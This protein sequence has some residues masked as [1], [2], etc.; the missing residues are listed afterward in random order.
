MRMYN[1][2]NLI[3]FFLVLFL[4][5]FTACSETE[6]IKEPS[7]I[8]TKSLTFESNQIDEHIVT[9]FAGSDWTASLS[10]TS[11]IQIDPTTKVGPKGEAKVILSCRANDG[12]KE[13]TS[14]LTLKVENE[15]PY[16][17]KITQVPQGSYLIIDTEQVVF[18]VDPLL[19]N[20]KGAFV[21]QLNV[22]SNSKWAIRA[23]PE[24]V[25]YVAGD[26]KESIDGIQTSINLI[27]RAD[28]SLF[29]AAQM[30]GVIEIE[31][32]SQP[33]ELKVI[34]MQ[35]TSDF[36]TINSLGEESA[37]FLMSRSAA[38]GNKFMVTMSI[39]SNTFW[40]INTD[41][42]PEWLS[43][44][45]SDN[46]KEYATSLQTSKTINLFFNDSLIDTDKLE[47][48][49][50]VENIALGI[51]KP[52]QIIFPGTGLDYFE[53]TLRIPN[54]FE[55]SASRWDSNWNPIP[56]A[57][58]EM[59]FSMLSGLDYTGL[60]N[61]PFKF[62]FIK[63]QN[64]FTMKEEIHWAGIDYVGKSE[65]A[66]YAL[67][68]K[69]EFVLYVQDNFEERREGYLIVAGKDVTFEDLFIDGTEDLKPEYDDVKTHFAQL[70]APSGDFD[71]E[72]Q[73]N[74]VAFTKEGDIQLF[75]I[76]S[77]PE[78]VSA[79]FGFSEWLSINFVRADGKFYLEVKAKPNMTGEVRFQEVNI[80]QFIPSDESEE[81]IYTFFVEQ[82]GE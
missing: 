47:T 74:Y 81:V 58:M 28:P 80:M 79:D 26:D 67:L 59:E 37:S 3:R 8:D 61:A 12:T 22:L 54:E 27:F 21:A 6:V 14:V 82:A 51:K 13:R 60:H 31:N 23:L 4:G 44:P 68:N 63:G 33:G 35:A 42:L 64:G 19:N 20:K 1:T 50:I 78:M 30:N 38:A 57:V 43:I 69:H 16:Q 66:T 62:F 24:W 40:T 7:V 29:D 45:V 53:C 17:I 36:R 5:F 48:E 10:N 39:E 25:S 71:C 2:T 65:Q 72:I 15:E 46:E 73:D 34:P 49:I 56:G 52:V 18:E 70:G 77:S 9:F 32:L 55:F 41:N 76:F 75:E 11:W